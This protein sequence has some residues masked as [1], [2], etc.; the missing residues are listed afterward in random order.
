MKIGS[1]IKIHFECK[2]CDH[3]WSCLDDVV[4]FHCIYVIKTSST[5]VIKTMM[6]VLI[7]KSYQ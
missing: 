7:K 6:T 2:G 4:F 1:G 5:E 3:M